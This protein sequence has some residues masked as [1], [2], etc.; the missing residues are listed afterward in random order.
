MLISCHLRIIYE[1]SDFDMYD[2]GR[3]GVCVYVCMYVLE[4]SIC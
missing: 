4:Q 2:G 3:G 1:N